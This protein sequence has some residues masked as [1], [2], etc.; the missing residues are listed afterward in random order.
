MQRRLRAAENVNAADAA[1][2][3]TPPKS[4]GKG[5]VNAARSGLERSVIVDAAC[6]DRE[7]ECGSA[8]AACSGR[9]RKC[10]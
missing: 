6:S 4:G 3:A 9:E 1:E 8:D 10:K 7:R 2:S 5:D